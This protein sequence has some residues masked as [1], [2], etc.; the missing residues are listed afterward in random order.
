[1]GYDVIYP[2]VDAAKGAVE[3]VIERERE[4]FVTSLAAE[5]PS[6]A[7]I[8]RAWEDK[9]CACALI[10]E[11]V[12]HWDV[13]WAQSEYPSSAA[14]EAR[15]EVTTEIRIAWREVTRRV[16]STD[17]GLVEEYTL[18]EPGAWSEWHRPIGGV[19]HS[20]PAIHLSVCPDTR[21]LIVEDESEARVWLNGQVA[22]SRK[23]KP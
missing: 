23:V 16:I 14:S 21:T 5:Q 10:E 8:K 22:T 7:A 20:L 19:H 4:A 15:V 12:Q 17:D 2:S 13:T 6:P 11:R 3:R 18:G 1:M 9:T